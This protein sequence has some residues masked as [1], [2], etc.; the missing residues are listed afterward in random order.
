MACHANQ[1]AVAH[2]SSNVLQASADELQKIR[3][4]IRFTLGCLEDYHPSA[5]DKENLS[6]LDKY[7]LHM[8][9]ELDSTI[10]D[11]IKNY[12]FQRVCKSVIFFLTN[13]VSALYYTGIKDRLYCD[14]QDSPTR[15]GS[16][17]ILLQLF[18]I[19]TQ[20]IA[21]IVPHL[22]EEMF[23][24]LPQK[25]GKSFFTTIHNQPEDYWKND[26]VAEVMD[27][28]LLMKKEITKAVGTSTLDTA[29]EVTLS[30]RLAKLMQVFNT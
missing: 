24:H 16:Q 2:I 23:M 10:K 11:D 13:S 20:A 22:V 9:Y 7:L 19:I 17:F 1:D 30:Y 25:N 5:I 4:I 15:R 26:T 14:E 8:L 18:E 21:P 29:V 3:S 28:V 12:H 27:S 6:L